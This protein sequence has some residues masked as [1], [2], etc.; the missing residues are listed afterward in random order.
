MNKVQRMLEQ[1]SEDV[2]SLYDDFDDGKITL[3]EYQE[4]MHNLTLR[5]EE[6]VYAEIENA[7]EFDKEVR[8]YIRRRLLLMSCT[9]VKDKEVL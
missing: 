4:E 8:E 6:R 2:I 7:K 9:P 1:F 3:R 5:Y